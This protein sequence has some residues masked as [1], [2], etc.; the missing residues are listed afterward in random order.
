MPD[1]ASAFQKDGVPSTTA[2][3]AMLH[4]EKPVNHNDGDDGDN[5]DDGVD[6]DDGDDG[7]DDDD[8]NNNADDV[9]T[10]VA[11]AANANHLYHSHDKQPLGPY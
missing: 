9:D 10:G 8:D 6:D 7:G 4:N 2:P 11:A 5:D 3:T 1:P